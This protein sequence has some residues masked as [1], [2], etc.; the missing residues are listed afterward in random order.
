MLSITASLMQLIIL[1]IQLEHRILFYIISTLSICYIY[2]Y[3][4][5]VI[6]FVY[7]MLAGWT[8]HARFYTFSLFIAFSLNINQYINTNKNSLFLFNH[9]TI[10]K[11]LFFFYLFN[12]KFVSFTTERFYSSTTST[13]FKRTSV[14]F[15]LYLTIF[16]INW[17]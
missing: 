2:V 6:Y 3:R 16:V 15:S 9:F 4:N 5:V 1:T 12:F 10:Q 14:L 11:F 8:G 7:T 13:E 17:N